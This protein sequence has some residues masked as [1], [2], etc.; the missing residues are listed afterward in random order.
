MFMS[1]FLKQH[2]LAT[3]AYALK[4]CGNK[5]DLRISYK[6]F[7]A[8]QKR[9]TP[10]KMMLYRLAIQMPKIYNGKIENEDWI[11]MNFRQDFNSRNDSVLITENSNS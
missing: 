3:S 1:A 9:G 10:S 5:T 2:L 11:D 8:L 4:L 6:K 7:Y